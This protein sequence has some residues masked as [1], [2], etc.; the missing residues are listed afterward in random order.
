M[1][2]DNINFAIRGTLIH[3]PECGE[4][5]ILKK[6]L[7]LVD[8][9][10]DISSVINENDQNYN[11]TLTA[12]SDTEKL[13]TLS[14]HEYLVPGLIDIHMHAPQWPLIAK[15]LHILLE[16]WLQQYAFPIEAKYED[17]DYAKTVYT[18]LVDT[19]LANGTTAALYF[20]SIHLEGTKVLADI[21]LEKGQRAYIGKVTM[22]NVDSC[23]DYYRDASTE[24]G[25]KQ[26]REFIEYV[27]G[28]QGNEHGLIQPVI[29]PRFIP[30]CT[31]EMLWGL[32]D[33][34]KEYGCHI[35]SHASESDW[36]HGYGIERYG[37]TDT[38]AFKDMGLLTNKTVLAHCNF[39]SD[40]DM[41]LI[42]SHDAGIAHCPLSNF[43][44]ANAVF[45]ARKALDKH[46]NCGL[47]SDVSGGPSPSILNSCYM[48]ITSSRAMEDGVNPNTDA[49]E[50]GTPNSRINFKEAFWMATVGGGQALDQKIGK[51]DQGYAFDAMLI[52]TKVPDTNLIVWDGYDTDEDIFQKFIYNGDRKNIKKVWVQGQ[53][54]KHLN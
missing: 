13:L 3:T 28:M 32:G 30:S 42:K 25:L 36:E 41:D 49:E 16:D 53:L 27:R 23:P 21:C 46:L 10:G 26:T 48:A 17:V 37:K 35:Q 20:G 34:A 4:L 43:Y 2:L 18:S 39:L 9:K 5:E 14:E 47:G 45:P 29:T 54:V 12:L 24:Q 8:E 22:D 1:S 33:L 40:E 15:A 52:N 38:F 19:L 11:E 6:A 50:R 51:F 44:F 7:L 31:D